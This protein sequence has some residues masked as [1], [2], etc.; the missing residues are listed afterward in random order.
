MAPTVI[1]SVTQTARAMVA[2]WGMSEKL[3]SILYDNDSEEVFLGRSVARSKNISEDTANL[4]D[5]EVKSIVDEAYKRCHKILQDKLE[6]L[7]KLAK[8]LLEYET[9]NYDEI[10]DLLNGISPN[11][12][13]LD[14]DT[15]S[16]HD[17]SPAV[18]KTGGSAPAP[19]N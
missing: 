12:D 7:H 17:T 6:D 1:L 2:Q 14:N 4:I 3:G 10:K 8:G 16:K 19:A 9:L 5:K 11:R 13:D 18:P 15:S